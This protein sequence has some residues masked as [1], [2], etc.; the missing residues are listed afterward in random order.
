MMMGVLSIV[1]VSCDNRDDQVVVTEPAPSA[2][3][4]DIT[5][6]FNAGN[7]YTVSQGIALN[8]TDVVLVYRNVNTTG[9]GLAYWQ[10]IPTTQ[11]LS[12][13]RELDY[14]FRFDRE[15]VD[16]FT[17]ATFDYNEL[18]PAEANSFINNQRF[19]I[20]L[21]PAFAGKNAAVNYEDYKSVINFYNIPDRD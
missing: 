2:V 19:R 4:L 18:T 11:Y 7:S 6:N 17:V 13:G 16:I 3:M 9:T 20:V 1:A 15:Y 10:L 21:V 8:N 14:D 12:G 5:A